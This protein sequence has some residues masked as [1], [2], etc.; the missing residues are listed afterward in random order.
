ME[1]KEARTNL[2]KRREAVV[3]EMNENIAQRQAL[4]ARMQELIKEANMLNGETRM[5]KSLD[6]KKSQKP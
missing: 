5:L 2:A 4:Q 3:K 6:G 1:I